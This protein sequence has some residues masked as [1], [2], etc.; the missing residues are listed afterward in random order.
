MTVNY[1]VKD[2]LF[3]IIKKWYVVVAIA[4]VFAL[5][6]T[7]LSKA[8]YEYAVK[9]YKERTSF[10]ILLEEQRAGYEKQKQGEKENVIMQETPEVYP[11]INA[12]AFFSIN[13]LQPAE[14]VVESNESY[15]ENL[16][17]RQDIINNISEFT[18]DDLFLVPQFNDA[19]EGCDSLNYSAFKDSFSIRAIPGTNLMQFHFYN[20][21]ESVFDIFTMNYATDISNFLEEKIGL[22]ITMQ[23]EQKALD[24]NPEEATTS[25]SIKTQEELELE[26]QAKL[27]QERNLVILRE[28]SVQAEK[29]KY[30]VSAG[31]FGALLACFSILIFDFIKRSR[32]ITHKEAI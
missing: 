15:Q 32:N 12:S 25:I 16:R 17:N 29:T 28:P 24:E 1:E 13:E 4:I 18:K 26:R 10:Q 23:L 30:M 27:I 9:K 19:N 3:I 20:I 5:V 11:V 14:Q 6:A 7:P 31:L 21:P 8:S 22:H 2:L